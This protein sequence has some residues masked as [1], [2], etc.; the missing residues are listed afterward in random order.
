MIR[1]TVYSAGCVV[2]RPRKDG[3]GKKPSGGG[4]P[5]GL[6]PVGREPVGREPASRELEVLLIWTRN[7][8]DPTLPKG[9]INDSEP[10]VDAARREVAEETG[11]QVEILDENPVTTERIL[12]RHPP[13][14]RKVIH[15]FPARV[16]GGAPEMRTEKELI[17]RVRWLPVGEALRLMKR[18]DEITALTAIAGRYTPGA[19]F[20][21]KKPLKGELPCRKDGWDKARS[22]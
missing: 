2:L 21:Y 16:T 9:K 1:G 6:E 7:Y 17:T 15:W 4:E 22:K 12:D 11:Y 19:T 14:L 13:K 8:A 10:T 5:V 3:V 18:P 20:V